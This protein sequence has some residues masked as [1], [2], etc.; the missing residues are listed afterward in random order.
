MLNDSQAIQ[1]DLASIEGKVAGVWESRVRAG[2]VKSPDLIP[3]HDD[4]T[5]LNVGSDIQARL[6]TMLKLLSI[7][8]G[9][10][11]QPVENREALLGLL[12]NRVPTYPQS[13][14]RLQ[15][16]LSGRLAVHVREAL[17][18]QLVRPDVEYSMIGFAEALLAGSRNA[19]AEVREIVARGHLSRAERLAGT[20]R[21]AIL[22][23]VHVDRAEKLGPDGILKDSQKV[24]DTAAAA[25]ANS[26]RLPIRLRIRTNPSDD[27][28][29]QDLARF[30]V[31]R[32]VKQRVRSHI[33]LRPVSAYEKTTDVDVSFDSI[34][35]LV[36]SMA[37]LSAQSSSY[38][39]HFEDV[40]NPTKTAL[41]LQ[42]DIQRISVDS[43]LN[44]LNYAITSFNINPAQWALQNVN[45]ARTQYNMEVD[46]YNT[47][48][49][50]YNATSST[51][52]R[53][54]YLPYT[55]RQGTVRHGWRMSGSVT[56][57]K[58]EERFQVD[59]VDSDFVRIGTRPEDR[60]ADY[61]RDDFLDIP[62]GTE[63]L[64][65]Q[66]VKAAE[67]I[68]AK[69]ALA[70]KGLG[71]SMR[72]DVS[73]EERAIVVAA[74]FPFD[75]RQAR[76][77]TVPEWAAP[78]I[79][80]MVLPEVVDAPTPSVHIAEPKNRPHGNT[81]QDI[82]AFY[83][84]AVALI[85]SKDGSTGSGALISGDGLIL[86]A[87]HVLSAEPIEVVFPRSSDAR[88]R[89]A[90]VIFV[91]EVHDV[92]LLRVSDYR[93]D[94]WFEVS[95]AE[96]AAAGEPVVAIGNPAIPRAGTAVAS[97]STGIVAKPYDPSRATGLADLVADIA[98][99]SGS[100]GGPLLSRKTGKIVG[101]VTAVVAPS[102]NED[103]AT[104]GY[105]AVAAPSSELGKWLGLM[106]RPGSGSPSPR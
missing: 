25:F 66:L 55:F 21:S 50:L 92:A 99:A 40:P 17:R 14:L 49:Q 59:E 33:N 34:R 73:P 29:V 18:E 8:R 77:Y 60:N 48:V 74:L 84:P 26:G 104:S 79:K 97:I 100:S 43:A 15:Q 68:Q 46:R 70:A 24:R 53:P 41:K 36:P 88:R 7:D 27:P 63:R 32:A 96:A 94:R 28:I 95:L 44:S 101:V 91:N 35:L 57:G 23:L 72:S 9:Q 85:S 65:E 86:T 19:S 31:A 81:P 47:T 22:A 83:G 67:Q 80:T 90:R 20:G 82:I 12:R 2:N 42:L 62:V 64:A 39:S 6:D 1:T 78:V 61:R 69:V 75:D 56:V 54:V 37:D 102:I 105:W 30:A 89:T 4:L 98:V 11:V 93:A 87:A 10:L 45:Y 38:L 103:F 76:A 58:A 5:L 52:S 51:I 106:Y 71:I 3:F 13:V 16:T